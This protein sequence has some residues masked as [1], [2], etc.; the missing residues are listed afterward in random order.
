MGTEKMNGN[1]RVT[2]EDL[3]AIGG[4]FAGFLYPILGRLGLLEWTTETFEESMEWMDYEHK[5]SD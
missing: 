3:S 5:K 2:V 1:H 4:E